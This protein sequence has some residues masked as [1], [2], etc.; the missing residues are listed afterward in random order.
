MH[1][2]PNADLAFLSVEY[3]MREVQY[4]WLLRYMHA[5]GASFFFLCVYFHMF[6]NFYYR[7]Y[8]APRRLLWAV[9]VVIL[10]IM[11][12][13]AFMGYVLPWGQMSF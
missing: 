10:I 4:G 12:L 11:I 5:N 8:V 13:T 7:S 2:V 3:I 9:G 6:R 1:Y